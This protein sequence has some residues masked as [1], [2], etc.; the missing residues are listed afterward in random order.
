MASQTRPAFC[1]DSEVAGRIARFSPQFRDTQVW[2]EP[3]IL[4]TFPFRL[5]S[6][7]FVI[8]KLLAPVLSL[9]HPERIPIVRYLEDLLL[10]EQ[11]AQFL[12]VNVH[13]FLTL[14]SRIQTLQEPFNPLFLHEVSES[15]GGLLWHAPLC[16]ISLLALEAQHSSCIVLES[17]VSGSSKYTYLSRPEYLWPGGTQIQPWSQLSSN[18][19]AGVLGNLIVLSSLVLSPP[20][21]TTP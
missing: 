5:L 12:L 10:M 13:K 9:L 14:L 4:L 19:R 21:Q 11:L 2:M 20:G 15:E 18:Q 7:P 8:T 1:H 16:P 6:T 17:S 3:S